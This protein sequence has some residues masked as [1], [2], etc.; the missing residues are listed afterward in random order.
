MPAA[1]RKS[2]AAMLVATTPGDARSMNKMS[3]ELLASS[4]V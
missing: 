4:S 3:F 2:P 1:D